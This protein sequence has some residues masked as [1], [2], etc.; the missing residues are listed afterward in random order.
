MKRKY[1]RTKKLVDRPVQIAV[2]TRFL[3]HVGVF[4]VVG[5]ALAVL[6]PGGTFVDDDG[7]M[8]EPMIEAI[9]AEGLTNGCDVDPARYCPTDPVLRSEM[10]TFIVRAMGET[11]NVPAFQAYFAD[12]AAGK[13]FTP[14]VERVYELGITKGC[15]TDPLVF[16]PQ[17]EVLRSEM[18][19]FL[20]R[21][22]EGDT[23]LPGYQAYFADV[24]AGKWYTP[25][26][27][28][29][30]ELGITNGCATNPLRYC[31]EDTVLRD[32]MAS[33]LGRTL[34]LTPIVPPPPTTSSTTTTTTAPTT[35]GP[36]M[37][38]IGIDI[39][40][41]T[42]RNSDDLYG[43]YWE[44]LSGFGGTFDELIANNYADVRQIV[45]VKPTDVAF[46][47]DEDCGTWSSDLS[48]SKAPTASFASGIW[49]VPS[50]IAP[51]LWQNTPAH[52][53]CYW[54]RLSGFSGEL[55]DTIDNG[56]VDG[57][58]STIVQVGASDIGFSADFDCGNWT[59]LGP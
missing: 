2:V 32:Q 51:G 30:Y 25:Y 59:Y 16:C 5:A 27:E 21:Q 7:N 44:R 4:M 26:A 33:F 11:G 31:P 54:E 53:G 8:H 39:P 47:T 45:E 10:A 3:F 48:P 35:F 43:C 41:G 17:D 42:F 46:S 20:V 37:H 9:A 15:G 22:V 55:D 1:K 24:P 57:Q 40:A 58:T 19:A 28:R 29:L 52:T 56:Y 49:Q 6:P 36:G 14:F 18:A 13:W 34:G 23:N 12:V 50:E 38:R